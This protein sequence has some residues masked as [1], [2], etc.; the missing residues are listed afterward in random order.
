VLIILAITFL[1]AVTVTVLAYFVDLVPPLVG[2]EASVTSSMLALR[3][4]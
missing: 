4:N 1:M 3:G 2:N